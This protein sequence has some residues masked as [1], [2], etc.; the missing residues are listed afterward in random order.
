MFIGIDRSLGLLEGEGLVLAIGGRGE[1]DLK[2]GEHP[3][4]FPG[5]VPVA[6]RL[7][8]GPILDLN[9][10]S[11]RGHWRHHLSRVGVCG[12]FELTR[13]GDFTIAVVRGASGTA[14]GQPFGDGDTIILDETS[15]TNAARLDLTAPCTLWVA[16]L[17]RL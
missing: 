10:M 2:P 14:D 11:R 1:I 15:R 3:A 6:A 5:D 16:D 9:V 17:W 7:P 12:P 13:R 8:G 4:V